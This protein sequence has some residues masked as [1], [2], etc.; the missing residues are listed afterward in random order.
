M[1]FLTPLLVNIHLGA[2]DSFI[3]INVK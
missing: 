2:K 3:S 1:K